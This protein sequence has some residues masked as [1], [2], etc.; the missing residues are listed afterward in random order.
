MTKLRVVR[1]WQAICQERDF[2]LK[3]LVAFSNEE[4]ILEPLKLAFPHFYTPTPD[5]W[6]PPLYFVRQLSQMHFGLD[7]EAEYRATGSW[8]SAVGRLHLPIAHRWHRKNQIPTELAE[9]FAAEEAC[10]SCG[11]LV[12]YTGSDYVVVDYCQR[13]IVSHGGAAVSAHLTHLSL[14]SCEYIDVTRVYEHSV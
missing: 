2:F 4:R 12:T 13:Q 6:R 7:E 9:W 8:L 10:I 14:V 3:W 5:D 11:D 1:N